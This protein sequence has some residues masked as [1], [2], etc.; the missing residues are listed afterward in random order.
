MDLGG[1]RI[2]EWGEAHT[3]WKKLAVREDEPVM[4]ESFGPDWDAA[5]V[6]THAACRRSCFV[7]TF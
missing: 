2:P 4:P 1:S 7:V 5:V 3:N 6:S